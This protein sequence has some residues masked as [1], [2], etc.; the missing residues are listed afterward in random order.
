[1]RKNLVV[2]ILKEEKSEWEHRT[3]LTPSDVKWLVK[4][5]IQVEVESNSAR[6]FSDKE[7]QK[8]GAKIVKKAKKAELLVGI[9]PPRHDDI[10]KNK[11]YTV[12]SH[13]TK[14][15][16]KNRPLLRNFVKKGVTLIDYEKITDPYGRRLIYFGRFAGIC[17]SA[18]SLYY[19]GKKMEWEGVRNPFTRLKPS[20]KYKSLE[21]LKKDFKKVAA[22]IRRRGLDER[23]TPL[24][25][26]ITGHGN[27]SKG[28]QEIIGMLDPVEIHPK[29]MG[30]FIRHQKYVKDKVYK[31]VFLREEKLRAKSGEGFYF[32]EYITHPE[33]FESNLDK[34]IMHMNVLIHT[35]YWDS[36]YPRM[37]TKSMIKKFYGKRKSRLKFIGDISCD[38]NGS[39]QLTYKTGSPD[40]AV[41]T[42]DPKKDKYTDGYENN[43]ISILAVDNLPSELPKDSSEDFSAIVRD[44]IYQLSAHGVLDISN[45]AA[46]P[47]EIRKAVITEGGRLTE[48]YKYLN[49]YIK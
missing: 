40:Q 37:V 2:G 48:E 49:K 33:R 4:K 12:F 8:S 20:W 22:H 39:I 47:K 14:G 21:E 26:G 19:F 28:A 32:E 42:Y 24:I 1:M 7:Y 45:H 31:I 29:D 43:G 3:P 36:R 15:Q 18:D 11:I 27:V 30:K 41:Y 44:Y 13:T 46:I 17:G 38:I 10:L 9:K 16:L 35:S 34:Y 6:T 23:L 5:G 25:I